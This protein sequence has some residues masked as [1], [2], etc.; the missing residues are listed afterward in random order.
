MRV[1]LR[2]ACGCEKWMEV[3]ETSLYPGRDLE[4]SIPHGDPTASFKLD[5][6]V[7]F[8]RRRFRFYGEMVPPSPWTPEIRIYR[9]VVP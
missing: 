1:C 7:T 6:M 3:D 5:A 8:S 2:T 4:V 9:E